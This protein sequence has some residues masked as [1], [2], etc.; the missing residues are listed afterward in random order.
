M[1]FFHHAAAAASLAG[2]AVAAPRVIEIGPA[3]FSISVLGGS[4]YKLPQVYN[5]HFRQVGKG[6]RAI[7]KVYQKFGIEF[8]P[9]LLA[10]LEQ[11]L[12]ELGITIPGITNGGKGGS[13]TTNSN[14]T[15]NAGQGEVSAVPQLFDS[16]YLAAVQIG[17]PPQT[18]MLDFDTGS[19]DLWVFSSETPATQQNG[20]ALY[21]IAKSTTSKRLA[22]AVWSIRYGDG[23]SSSGNVYLDTVSIG[24]VTV[25]SQAVESATRVSSSFTNDTASSGLLG[26]AFDTINQVTPTPQKTFFSNAMANLAMPLFTANL[27]KGAAGNYNFGFIDPTEFTGSISF[28]DVNTTAGFWQFSADGFAVGSSAAVSAPHEA[29]ADTGTTLLMLPQDIAAAYYKQV[30][31]AQNNV[32]V[33]GFV[34]SCNET[35]PDLTLNIGTY[36]AVVPG[37][38]INFAPADTDSFDTATICFGGVQT[39]AGL[40]FAIYGDIFLK[41]QFTVFNGGLKQLGF[42][43]KPV[44]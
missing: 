34:F 28:V 27:K 13:G 19:S 44:S 9:E 43:A 39:A 30:A 24:G 1:K 35:L 41:S 6:P 7:A 22:G 2:L 23:S 3:D 33:G 38:L 18:L 11:L 16:E 40:P 5:E 26:L 21:N 17:T 15:T 32:Q 4:T 37:S 20:Q 36:K 29:I 10:I 31:S 12:E 25:A 42:A 8:P 14:V